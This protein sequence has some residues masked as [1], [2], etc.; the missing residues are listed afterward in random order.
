MTQLKIGEWLI[1]AKNYRI[2]GE[3]G[4]RALEPKVFDVLMV[5]QEYRGEPVSQEIL[6]ERVWPDTHVSETIVRRAISQLRKLLDDD[7]RN[8][9]YVETV[10]KKGYRLIAPVIFLPGQADN[11]IDDEVIRSISGVAPK[12]AGEPS[13]AERFLGRKIWVWFLVFAVFLLVWQVSQRSPE[14]VDHRRQ[15][16]E[17]FSEIEPEFITR[18]PGLEGH[19]RLS[20]DGSLI[21][22][23]RK[24][25]IGG[26]SGI[27]TGPPDRQKDIEISMAGEDC[28]SPDWSPDGSVLGY[29]ATQNGV[30]RIIGAI[31]A[32][33]RRSG[34]RAGDDNQ[35]LYRSGG[36]LH[37]MDWAGFQTLIFAEKSEENQPFQ[38][39]RLLLNQGKEALT[40][41]P[42]RYWGDADP[43]VSP[44]GLQVG[45]I[46][47]LVP[48]HQ[49]VYVVDARGGQATRLT[50][51]N[52]EM[53]G[54]CWTGDSGRLI[55]SAYYFGRFV[56]WEVDP[57]G[58]QAKRFMAR[59]DSLRYPDLASDG[60]SLVCENRSRQTEIFKI[61]V[62]RDAPRPVLLVSAFKWD[63]VPNYAPDGKRIVFMST[64]AG[65]TE[66]WMVE[67]DGDNLTQL[68]SFGGPYTTNPAW[69][70]DSVNIAFESRLEG[71]GDIYLLNTDG[72][73]YRR[74]THE[75][76]EESLPVW[77]PDGRFIYFAS[78]RS[79]GWQIWRT[80][81]EGGAAQRMTQH[82]GFKAAV[83]EDGTTLYF[84]KYEGTGV[85]RQDIAGGQSRRIL[86]LPISQWGN[87]AASDDGIY[88]VDAE[89][90]IMFQPF[91]GGAAQL[92]TKP[93]HP[94]E[95]PGLTLSPGGQN[96]I[97]SRR[98]ANIGNLVI[99]KR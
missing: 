91:G 11:H 61:D 81:P 43:A 52:T 22:Y 86:D 64:R 23:V 59:D 51:L 53:A 41:P 82:G 8:P 56:L 7:A 12:K 29:I 54:L 40:T 36:R 38:L 94:P 63:T 9:R 27:M 32:G 49:D 62:T 6:D 77:S 70:P 21:A 2:S 1:D 33:A 42:Q 18:D 55:F 65:P 87:W 15:Q 31:N 47:T 57:K 25:L 4:V 79:D 28:R 96:L 60:Q 85:W 16:L 44:D 66:L 98:E 46:R 39:F 71:H 50:F 19:P 45:F 74:L 3:K 30:D 24:P 95:N 90:R 80:T 26:P 69:A 99:F 75:T 35:L 48:G 67:V 10:P 37:S 88:Y 93:D 92:I 14:I 89:N 68:T 20:P 76:S 73:L 34:S 13:L 17:T 58:S 97:F 72:G 5:L 78:D 84:S 83:S